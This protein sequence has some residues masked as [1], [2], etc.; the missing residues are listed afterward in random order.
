MAKLL[1]P[2]ALILGLAGCVET[3]QRADLKSIALTFVENMHAAGIDPIKL[4]D[5]QMGLA[6]AGCTAADGLSSVWR[7]DAPEISDAVRTWCAVALRIAA[8][9]G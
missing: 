4:D 2:I 3:G 6:I 9:E 8:D 5:K 1:L 7:P